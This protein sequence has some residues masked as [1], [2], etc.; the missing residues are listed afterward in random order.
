MFQANVPTRPSGGHAERVEHAADPAGAV[1]PLRDRGPPALGG[2]APDELLVA[3]QPLEPVEDGG[4]GERVVLHQT[5]HGGLLA[6]VGSPCEACHN[7]LVGDEIGSDAAPT[8]R[9]PARCWPWLVA[10]A[11]VVA[12][13]VALRR[14]VDPVAAAAAGQPAGRADA[15]R[16]RASSTADAAA[17]GA[18]AAL[19]D[20]CRPIR[21]AGPSALDVSFTLRNT[22]NA[23]SH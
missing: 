18:G 11:V 13:V 8:S 2:G 3:E 9:G 5:L 4:Q 21:P 7:R 15:P 1:G 16:C 17:A 20:V 10:A 23:R 19:S 12:G 14:G 22:S 6:V